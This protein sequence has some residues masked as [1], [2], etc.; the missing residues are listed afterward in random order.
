MHG[1]IGVVTQGLRDVGDIGGA[2]GGQRFADVER[3]DL[4]E[5]FAVFV[6]E[7]GEAVKEDGAVVGRQGGPAAF[8]EG[9]LG[10][11]HRELDVAL[12]PR[13]DLGDDCAVTG[14]VGVKGVAVQRFGPF[15]VDEQVEGLREEFAHFG[16][17]LVH[18]S[19]PVES[20]C[21]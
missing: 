2:G 19:A 14:I 10:G 12:V 11:R 7:V 3:L 20:S 15:A 4:G 18:R 6:H 21:L 17:N 8:A 16:K 13:G 9:L 1:E 5:D